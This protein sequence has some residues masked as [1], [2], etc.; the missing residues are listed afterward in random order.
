LRSLLL[1]LLL[2]SGCYDLDK[3]PNLYVANFTELSQF[4]GQLGGGGYIEGPQP[5]SRLDSPRGICLDGEGIAYV[6][7]ANA[8]TLSKLGFDGTVTRVAGIAYVAGGED[9]LLNTSTFLEPQSCALSLD[10]Q[11]I[12][13]TDYA[14]STLRQY[15]FATQALTTLIGKYLEPGNTAGS[16]S[17]ARLGA[18]AG[19]AVAGAY[20]YLTDALENN[21]RIIDT[22]HA[23]RVT[24]VGAGFGDTDQGT[25]PGASAAFNGP[26]AIAVDPGGNTLYI[27]DTLNRIIRTMEVL[28]P[29]TTADLA[30]SF[31][32]STPNNNGVPFSS[33]GFGV[34]QDLQ[35]YEGTAGDP[36][37][38][39]LFAADADNGLLNLDLSSGM[40][41]APVKGAPISV[42]VLG[43]SSSLISGD[44]DHH[45]V[46]TVPF[47]GGSF[48]VLLQSPGVSGD[49]DGSPDVATFDQPLGM[50]V[51]GGELYVADSE[52]H[53]IR[54]LKS[55]HTS[56][57]FVGNYNEGN[58]DK[59]LTD[60]TFGSP[61]DVVFAADGTMYIADMGQ[62][63]IRR[64]H[65]GAVA[66]WAG[67]NAFPPVDPGKTNGV[68]TA[69]R[70]DAP[71]ALAI[72]DNTI[73]VADAGA[74][75][76]IRTVD[77]MTAS[78]GTLTLG[79]VSQLV[80]CGTPGEFTLGGLATD[81]VRHL[82][83]VSVK[84]QC[85]VIAV[86]LDND[87]SVTVLAGQA[88]GVM[89]GIGTSA[90]FETTDGLMFD[91]GHTLYVSDGWA[92]MVRAIDTTTQRVSTIAGAK[93]QHAVVLGALPAQLNQT[94]R[95][96]LW[97]GVGLMISVHAENAVLY[98]H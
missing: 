79:N 71:L 38:A 52:N 18:P 4:S 9:G 74:N 80:G 31:G 64:V 69:A 8:R 78:V 32:N 46:Q 49:I 7:D 54:V 33:A 40:V 82:L 75:N 73:Y 26:Q 98:A 23:D 15:T 2:V 85:L 12:Y 59:G 95:F 91:G 1:A 83:Y 70:F 96:A 77:V 14:A 86:D 13:V 35:Y 55:D 25:V 60:S 21:V 62:H 48:D 76:L 58:D 39:H 88:F 42:A 63:N 65:D 97:P 81:A 16:P 29:N 6:V 84:A 72:I 36:T 90:A 37:T 10:K 67:Q 93:Q 17:V 45:R 22:S 24:N 43:A 28:S 51:Q 3:L 61:S 19:I 56:A 50:S 68:G 53:V 89:D 57:T 20:V 41:T 47:A 44:R 27:A 92:G 94:S 11:S 66:T 30:G 87:N 5:A 34:I